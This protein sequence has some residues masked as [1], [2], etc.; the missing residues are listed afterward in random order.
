MKLIPLLIASITFLFLL[1]DFN[2]RILL[3]D[4]KSSTKE[5]Y[6]WLDSHNGTPQLSDELKQ[7]L[8]G[9]SLKFGKNSSESSETSTEGE[10]TLSI[11]QQNKQQGVLY[12]LYIGDWLYSLVA[13]IYPEGNSKVP[14]F[15][16]LRGEN[17]K[18]R[19][20][21]IKKIPAKK[22]FEGYRISI[23]G[24]KAITFTHD[25]QNRQV[26]LTMYQPKSLIDD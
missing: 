14:A 23:Q 17:L 22:L 26:L 9:A 10:N 15:G 13:V 18:S 6:Q 20:V 16:L 24:T 11:E 25:K 21:K 8:Q 4:A 19:E 3:S 1:L 7:I 12:K 2:D 5:S